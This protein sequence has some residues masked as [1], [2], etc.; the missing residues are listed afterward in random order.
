MFLLIAPS[1]SRLQRTAP[2]TLQIIKLSKFSMKNMNDNISIIQENPAA[3][4]NTFYVPRTVLTFLKGF[5]DVF[6]NR[7]DMSIRCSMNNQKVGCNGGVPPN[8]QNDCLNSFFV[9]GSLLCEPD[10]FLSFQSNILSCLLLMG[11]QFALPTNSS[12]KASQSPIA[13][14]DSVARKNNGYRT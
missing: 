11:Q 8:F 1:R 6:C 2:Q 4:R 14:D 7:P 9:F 5:C 13:P 10:Q 12:T 3:L